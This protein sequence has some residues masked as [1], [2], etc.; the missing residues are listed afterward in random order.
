MKS[1][2]C[3]S[4]LRGHGVVFA[5]GCAGL[6]GILSCREDVTSPNGPDA[7]VASVAQAPNTWI[8]RAP[9]PF[10]SLVHYFSSAAAA[11]AAGQWFAYTFGGRDDDEG[12]SVRTTRY[13]IQTNTWSWQDINSLVESSE[14]NGVG[15]IGNKFYMSGG[16]ATCCSIDIGVWN[17]LWV[18]DISANK[19]IRKAD[20]P[21]ATMFG[22]TGVIDNKLYVLA[23][24]CSGHPLD[25]G[26]CITEG[27]VRQFYRYDPANNSWINR[28]QPPHFHTL[29]AGAVINGKFYVVGSN[30]AYTTT[31]GRELDVYNPV[32][33]TW[34]SK[35]P[36]PT[37][38]GRF[39][40]AVIQNRMFVIVAGPSPADKVRAYSYDP[41]TNTW[42][43][44]A[45]PPVFEQIVRVQLDGQARLFLAGNPSSYLY[46]P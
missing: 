32:T 30:P 28:R 4:A 38:G 39:S 7:A 12:R 1:I 13:N 40:A 3:G 8:S 19:Q 11:N 14:M 31:S 2:C 24:Y 21:R 36:I 5:L 34:T 33:N 46:A 41:V 15:K 6:L 45:S 27:P 35:A 20:M 44:R 42:K 37:V 10:G 18:Y 23:G 29:G 22:Q 16:S 9:A 26:R 25:P 17:S 43:S